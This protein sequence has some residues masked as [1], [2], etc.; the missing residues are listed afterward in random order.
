MPSAFA[1]VPRIS[2]PP[3][4]VYS[5]LHAEQLDPFPARGAPAPY[6]NGTGADYAAVDRLLAS[7]PTA[8]YAPPPSDASSGH[9]PSD[10]MPAAA[11]GPEWSCPACTLD[12]AAA[13][14]VCAACGHPRMWPGECGRADAILASGA[15]LG[16]MESV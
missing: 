11:P 15:V 7:A 13:D 8:P 10:A 16:G 12:N 5:P 2:H 3:P 14:P 1:S 9:W 6:G 4:A